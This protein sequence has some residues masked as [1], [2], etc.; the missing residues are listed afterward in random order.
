MIDPEPPQ[1][2]FETLADVLRAVVERAAPVGEAPDGEFGGEDDFIAPRAVFG[3]EFSDQ[4]LAE[5]LAIDVGG[6]PE[7]DAKLE[8]A[9]HRPHRITLS[10]GPIEPA[11]AHAA[12]ADCGDRPVLPKA[13][14][15][16]R[17]S[18]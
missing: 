10:R 4:T 2:P 13:P 1:R 6:V 9:R 8:R 15:P 16:H 11:E 17:P 3:Q 5:T 18:N 7:I 12:E 14:P